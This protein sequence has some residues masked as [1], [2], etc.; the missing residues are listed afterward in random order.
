MFKHN[1]FCPH[2]SK[3]TPHSNMECDIC[4]KKEIEK[5][6][7]RWKSLTLEQRIEELRQWIRSI[8]M[9]NRPLG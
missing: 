5:E 9:R 6:E 1:A 8:E 4:K 3:E 7:E 2:C